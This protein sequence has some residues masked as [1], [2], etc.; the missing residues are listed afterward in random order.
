MPRRAVEFARAR[1]GQSILHH[2][3][4]LDPPGS[5]GCEARRWFCRV[6]GL[7]T[8]A[9]CGGVLMLGSVVL[10]K[11]VPRAGIRRLCFRPAAILRA[12]ARPKVSD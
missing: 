3:S 10:A 5:S 9:S 2:S 7:R 12:C 6:A 1:R 11:R 8:S 4:V